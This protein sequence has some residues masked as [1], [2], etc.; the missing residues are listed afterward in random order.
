[1]KFEATILNSKNKSIKEYKENNLL[2]KDILDLIEETHN[3]E[4]K[5]VYKNVLVK[6]NNLKPIEFDVLVIAKTP[7]GQERVI[8][9]ELKE[10]D[11]SKVIEQAIVRRDFVDYSYVV[12]D[13]S[14]KL[15]VE[16]LLY[17]WAD[18]VKEYKIGFFTDNTLLLQ[19]KYIKKK[20]K[21]IKELNK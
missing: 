12:L 11:V 3:L 16:Y 7:T 9:I 4:I 15:L 13:T 10:S 20:V 18:Y 6:F 8:S 19:S 2:T 21:I 14:I 17:V 5:E 1:M